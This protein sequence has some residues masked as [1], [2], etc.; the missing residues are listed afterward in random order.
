MLQMNESRASE[1]RSQ[2]AG[3]C[4]STAQDVRGLSVDV[5]LVDKVDARLDGAV[6]DE[7]VHGGQLLSGDGLGQ[8][9]RRLHDHL[10]DLLLLLLLLLRA[11]F[12]TLPAP[13]ALSAAGAL[14]ACTC[15]C[16]ITLEV[17]LGSRW[18]L[19]TTRFA[20]RSRLLRAASTGPAARPA[21][22][23][24]WR[25]A[26]RPIKRRTAFLGCPRRPNLLHEK[27]NWS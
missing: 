17:D 19:L 10:G 6:A 7:L 4:C 16:G 25:R 13:A 12:A 11:L 2:N 15:R 5:K 9:P 23:L 3:C 18:R 26:H 14:R 8:R 21:G 20:A 22:R 27:Y 1:K 24:L